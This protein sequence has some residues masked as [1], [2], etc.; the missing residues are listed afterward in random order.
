MLLWRRVPACSK[1]GHAAEYEETMLYLPA[2]VS[3]RSEN[4]KPTENLQTDILPA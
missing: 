3:A 1:I 2:M 4:W